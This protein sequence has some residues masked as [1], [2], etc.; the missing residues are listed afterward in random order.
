[1]NLVRTYEAHRTH[2]FLS[3]CKELNSLCVK[4]KLKFAGHFNKTNNRMKIVFMGTPEFAVPSLDILVKS[5]YDIVGVVPLTSLTPFSLF[6]LII[7]SEH[8]FETD[9]LSQN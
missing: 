3:S 2:R 9:V 7:C 4:E 1:M 8:L 5:G 6:N